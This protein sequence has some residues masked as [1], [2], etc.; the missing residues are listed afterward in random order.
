MKSLSDTLFTYAMEHRVSRFQQGHRGALLSAQARL[1][2]NAQTLRDMGRP[3]ADCL[4]HMAKAS[5]DLSLIHERAA[6]LAGLSMGLELGA[7]G[8]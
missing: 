1:D 7:L 4:E 5:A 8:R 2:A 6:F 3:A